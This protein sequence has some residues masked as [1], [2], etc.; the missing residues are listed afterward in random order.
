M[1][2]APLLLDMEHLTEQTCGDL[3]RTGSFGRLAYWVT[4][5]RVEQVPVR[6]AVDAGTIVCLVQRRTLDARRPVPVAFEAY[7]CD[8]DGLIWSVVIQGRARQ[9]LREDDLEIV[10]GLR[11]PDADATA[12]PVRVIADSLTGSRASMRP[13]LPL[14]LEPRPLRIHLEP[15]C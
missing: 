8:D 9:I 4:D 10:R 1:T 5:D 13:P 3:V 15:A 6:Y 14:P 11:L 12:V 2:A 7:G